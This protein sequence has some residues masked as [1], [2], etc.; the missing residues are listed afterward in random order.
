[1]WLTGG[2]APAAADVERPPLRMPLTVA[3]AVAGRVSCTLTPRLDSAAC[4]ADNPPSEAPL[5]VAG[6]MY[7][8]EG[9]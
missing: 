5:Q 9:K 1:M 4:S 3:A 6:S 2:A 8:R 7:V